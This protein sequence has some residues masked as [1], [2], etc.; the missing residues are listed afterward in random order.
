[1]QISVI[2]AVLIG[3]GAF[4][5]FLRYLHS[6]VNNNEHVVSRIYVD[7]HVLEFEETEIIIDSKKNNNIH[8]GHLEELIEVLNRC[9]FYKEI[10]SNYKIY[11]A[12]NNI[13]KTPLLTK[14]IHKETFSQV[15]L[16]NFREELQFGGCFFETFDDIA[17]V[18]AIGSTSAILDM[19]SELHD[20]DEI[21]R[22][23]NKWEKQNY[24]VT[25]IASGDVY[26]DKKNVLT[27]G[28]K[29]KMTF[30]GLLAIKNS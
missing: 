3:V 28:V 23:S 2:I 27:R 22:V 17:M 21:I 16:T 5:L 9:A 24:L 1:M 29:E 26:G 14:Y 18:H 25:A 20:K 15:E 30:L 4:I 6:N 8:I 13:L 7:N 19:C 11:V 12:I 10:Y